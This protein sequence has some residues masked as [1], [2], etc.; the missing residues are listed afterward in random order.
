MVDKLL[1][2]LGI[3]VSAKIIRFI[4]NELTDAEKEKQRQIEED[5]KS[6][7]AAK[8]ECDSEGEEEEQQTA[9]LQQKL[10]LMKQECADYAEQRIQEWRD[11]HK[12]IGN[13]IKTVNHA[14][15]DKQAVTPMRK[16]SLER[17]KNQLYEAKERCYA[18]IQYLKK[19]RI[20]LLRYAS[21]DDVETA[22][23]NGFPMYLPEAFP[24]IGKIIYADIA[25]FDEEGWMKDCSLLEV[26]VQYC[27]DL[28]ELQREDSQAVRLPFMVESYNHDCHCYQLSLTK[29]R[30][31]IEALSD[32]RLGVSAVVTQIMQ[33]GVK[34]LYDNN[35][36]LF[37]P[38]AN[39]IKPYK[40]PPVRAELQVYP[41]Q[42]NYGLSSPRKNDCPIIVSERPDEATASLRFDTFPLVFTPEQWE[43]VLQYIQEYNLLETEDEWKIGPADEDD[44][45][46]AAGNYMKLQFG[47]ELILLVQLQVCSELDET[48]VIPVFC[49]QLSL[50][51]RFKSD[52]IFVDIDVGM[53]PVNVQ[54]L[55][56]IPD[57]VDIDELCAFLFEVFAELRVQKENKMSMAG[58]IY[59]QQWGAVM[60]QL[61]TYLRKGEEFSVKVDEIYRERNNTVI[62]AGNAEEL[63]QK[64]EKAQFA[65]KQMDNAV[66]KVNYFIEDVQKEQYMVK[67]SP[68]CKKITAYNFNMPDELMDEIT[69]YAEAFP[70]AEIQQKRALAQ[71]R[72]GKMANSKL[73]AA[74][75]DGCNIEHQTMEDRLT[76]LSNSAIERNPAQYDALRR[77]H[78]EKNIFFIQGPPGTGKTTVIRE[79]IAQYRAMHPKRRILVVSQANV[80]VDNALSGILPVYKDLMVRCGNEDKISKELQSISL[81]ERYK[82]YIHLIKKCG[83]ESRLHNKWWEFVRPEQGMHSSIGEL[84]ILNRPVVGATC[85]GL[86]RRRIGLDQMSFDL[87]IVD[88]AG[89]ALPGELLIPILHAKKV[90]MIG[91]HQ[92]L[93]PVIHPALFDPDKIELEHRNM[94]IRDLFA[95]SMFQRLFERAPES[96]K[97]MLRTQYRMPAVIGTLVSRL[98][99]QGML[100]NG[101]GT[102][103]K[104]PFF[105][106]CNL[107]M[108]DFAKNEDYRETIE[109]GCVVNTYEV[110][111]VVGLLQQIAKKNLKCR[112]AVITPYR[113]QKRKLEQAYAGCK[114]EQQKFDV[115]INTIDAFQ[116]DEAEIVIYCTTR[117]L[118]PTDYFSDY[119][120][121]NVALSRAKNELIIL[122]SMKYF[123]R[124]NKAKSPLPFIAE[125][126]NQYG[127]VVQIPKDKEYMVRG[128]NDAADRYSGQFAEHCV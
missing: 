80:A 125:Y 32:T 83:T 19:Y 73:Q 11:M 54:N 109:N 63:K 29:G 5:W 17:L 127:K 112:V 44:F 85:I 57:H 15:H 93:P 74:M 4:T 72:I 59:F 104:Q 124:Y 79:L 107:T 12:D 122:G 58:S 3:F 91:D 18:Y 31:D 111:F 69:L 81:G 128:E 82:E 119:R 56:E 28:E 87:V 23:N 115:S 98:F 42:W 46:T 90:I 105:S 110:K 40:T 100:E 7:C 88:E 34:V 116:G 30:F 86:A 13:V 117:A 9:V 16:N 99:Y 77:A 62:V 123:K 48:A 55:D 22:F 94:A 52:D 6:Y 39:F 113:A 8:G 97:A 25:S 68:D 2:G 1:F 64:L 61:I 36:P 76:D 21:D 106:D 51:E 95:V 26:C 120:R 84:M 10:E 121:I 43:D 49:G 67:I 92:Q 45:S 47:E 102:E 126:I 78:E 71:L 37:L 114:I 53:T 65:H 103:L 33:D 70:Y 75:M 38:R 60:Q 118:R 96:N 14:L 20:W 35:L 101:V 27:C 41:T 50:K 24:Y 89:K 66:R 108:Y